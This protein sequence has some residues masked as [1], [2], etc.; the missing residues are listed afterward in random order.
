MAYQ[1]N[2][3]RADA[4]TL[5]SNWTLISGNHW[6]INSN[7]AV[8]GWANGV[9]RNYYSAA[10]FADDQYSQCV[11]KTLS[12][13]GVE[14]C[15]PLV[16]RTSGDFYYVKC[17]SSGTGLYKWVSGVDTQ[18][19]ST[20]SAVSVDD[21][22]RIEAEGSNITVKKN[23]T[24]IIG[25]ISDSSITSGSPGIAGNDSGNG[26][27]KVDDWEGGDITASY[28]PSPDVGA[29]TYTGYSPTVNIA[30]GPIA[31]PVGSG[32]T[33][34]TTYDLSVGIANSSSIPIG[35]GSQQFTTYAES[36]NIG[37]GIPEGTGPE[38]A[39]PDDTNVGITGYAVN[40][41]GDYTIGIGVGS[42]SISTYDLT[43]SSTQGSFIP[44]DVGAITTTGYAPI[45]VNSH[46]PSPGTATQTITGYVPLIGTSHFRT[47]D[48]A[49]VTITG[50]DVSIAPTTDIYIDVGSGA[51][52]SASSAPSLIRGTGRAPDVATLGFTGYTPD[53]IS[54]DVSWEFF[55]DEGSAT[56]S[57]YDLTL[58]IIEVH[59]SIPIAVGSLVIPGWKPPF[60]SNPSVEV[61]ARKRRKILGFLK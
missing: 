11:I 35:T 58:S 19:G 7:A 61:G 3:D 10:T 43:V 17:N 16:R 27:I 54:E 22:V 55:P 29:I 8:M 60:G 38:A 48:T 28:T 50:Y 6:G 24:T 15:G 33:T 36:L 13:N 31:I 45:D 57:T 59:K 12:T 14:Y 47:P 51:I 44:V 52:T 49:A 5:G 34:T 26:G 39:F 37:F 42:I 46:V 53:A 9:S 32:S 23:G 41:G 30:T 4:G 21:I 18:L 1:D 2:F 25:P 56:Y 40:V 20:V